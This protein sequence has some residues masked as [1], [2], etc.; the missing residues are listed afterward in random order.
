MKSPWPIATQLPD[1][2]T[3]EAVQEWWSEHSAELFHRAELAISDP[4]ELNIA[5]F[6]ALMAARAALLPHLGGPLRHD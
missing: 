6:E 5:M 4:K 1:E 3:L 2:W